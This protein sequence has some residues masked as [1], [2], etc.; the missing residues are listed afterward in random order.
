MKEIKKCIK[1]FETGDYQKAIKFGKKA[2]KRYPEKAEAYYCLGEAYFMEG[3]IDLAIENFKKAENCLKRKYEQHTKLLSSI[4]KIKDFKKRDFNLMILYKRLGDAHKEKT[5]LGTA[6]FYYD[7][8]LSLAR[9]LEDIEI[10]KDTLLSISEIL[11]QEDELDEAIKCLEEILMIKEDEK[12]KIITYNQIAALYFEKEEYNK[13]IEYLKKAIEISE[14]YGNYKD[15]GKTMLNLA[16]VYRE[17]KDYENTKYYLSEG[18]KRIQKTGDKYWL[19]LF[20]KYF[21]WYFRDKGDIKSA[22]EYLNKAYEIFE[23]IEEEEEAVEV[24]ENLAELE[25][26]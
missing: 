16:G 4:L 17:M 12:E 3:E 9:D 11:H 10:Q 20:L 6:I 8:T 19:G 26:E 21:G 5:N 25:E 22:K 2:V 15:S 13:A 24:L 18:L 23:S 7:K 1:Y 14:R